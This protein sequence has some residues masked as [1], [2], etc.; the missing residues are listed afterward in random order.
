MVEQRVMDTA[1]QRHQNEA[2]RRGTGISLHEF[3]IA[4]G[5]GLRCGTANRARCVACTL[6]IP[7]AQHLRGEK[8]WPLP[9]KR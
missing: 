9:P 4:R 3:D 5:L 7:R 8:P 1:S 6:P 2:D